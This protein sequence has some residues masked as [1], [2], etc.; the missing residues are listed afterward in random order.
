MSAGAANLDSPL[1]DPSYGVLEQLER[2][3]LVPL[4]VVDSASAAEPLGAA[5]RAGGLPCAE[6][7][8]RTEVSE[9]VLADLAADPELVVGAGTVICEE[10]VESVA[11]LGARFIVTPGFSRSVVRKCRE[12]G[13]P[14]VPGVATATEVMMALDEGLDVVKL[15][16]AQATGGPAAVAA[17]AA[18]FRN[19]RFI[20]T[21]GVSLQNM[22]QYLSQTA[23]M[24]VGGSWMVAPEL[25]AR[26][27]YDAVEARVREAV[28]SLDGLK[29]TEQ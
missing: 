28:S 11:E 1:A 9:Q 18:P 3:R 10:Q 16:P 24:A 26:G 12:L 23:V 27:D 17:L 20:P 2:L 29:P 6:V 14:V 13:I 4:V 19:V 8:M 7:A 5:L 22:T 15:F 21:G 25:L